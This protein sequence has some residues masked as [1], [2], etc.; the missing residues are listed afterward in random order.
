MNSTPRREANPVTGI[1]RVMDGDKLRLLRLLA[2][3]IKDD[4]RFMACALDAYCKQQGLDADELVTRL[5]TTPESIVRLSLCKRPNSNSSQFN[6]QVLQIAHYTTISQCGLMDV[7]EAADNLVPGAGSA[8]GKASTAGLYAALVGLR[9]SVRARLSSLTMRPVLAA[10]TAV[11]L[12]VLGCWLLLRLT[13]SHQTVDQLAEK[14][15]EASTPQREEGSGNQNAPSSSLADARRP[16]ADSS[17]TGKT[18]VVPTPD[19]SAEHPSR[20]DRGPNPDGVKGREPSVRQV[21]VARLKLEELAVLRDADAQRSGEKSRIRLRCQMTRLEMELPRAA[22][23]NGYDVSIRGA[24]GETLL[25]ATARSTKG[26][27]LRVTMDLS[28]VKPGRYQL[29]LSHAGGIPDCYAL[30]LER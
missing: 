26:K 13:T 30:L 27:N 29:C 12:L 2:A 22:G 6:E 5:A 1:D 21:A 8:A 4:P 25:S 17:Q 28:T 3:R 10:L 15:N 9:N 24:F 18:N 16:E 19:H 20:D 7:L 23:D 11:M 14:R